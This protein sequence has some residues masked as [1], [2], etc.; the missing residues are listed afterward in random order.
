MWLF[1]KKN[2]SGVIL[3]FVFFYVKMAMGGLQK[4]PIDLTQLSLEE[5]MEI[6]VT[7]VSRKPEPLSQ[8]PAAVSVLTSEDLSRLGVTHIPEALRW[9]PGMEVAR[10]D[11]NK[12]AVTARGSNSLYANKLLVLQDGRRLYS[13]VFSGVFWES[14]DF[15]L[16]DI[17]RIE[18]IRGPGATMW[19]SNAVNGIINIITK[20]ASM[21]QGGWTQLALGTEEKMLFSLRYGGKFK[22]VAYRVYGKYQNQDGFVDSSGKPTQDAWAMSSFGFRFDSNPSPRDAV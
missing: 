3:L 20:D 19:G 10:I 17:D 14:Q 4:S 7:L 8:A 12:W 13:P 21:T 16:E 22:N 5:L 11:A 15:L 1:E 9:I 2:P 6:E 18:V